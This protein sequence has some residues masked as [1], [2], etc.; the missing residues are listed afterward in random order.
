MSELYLVI[1]YDTP[2]DSRRAKLAR[3]LKGFGERRQY[4]VFEARLTREQ[5]AHLKGQ[6]EQLVDQKQ[7]ILAVYFLPPEA[8]SRTFRVGHETLKCLKEPDII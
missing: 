8:L 4:S 3:L 1:A 5:W 7:D 6:L 2:S